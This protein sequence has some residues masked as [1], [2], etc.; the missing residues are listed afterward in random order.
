MNAFKSSP[1]YAEATE[2]LRMFFLRGQDVDPVYLREKGILNKVYDAQSEVHVI[3]ILGY[4]LNKPFADFKQP[5]QELDQLLRSGNIC[6]YA[7]EA[8]KQLEKVVRQMNSFRFELIPLVVVVEREK[9]QRL[10][11][12]LLVKAYHPLNTF[13]YVDISG[14]IYNSLSHFLDKNMLPRGFLCYPKNGEVVFDKRCGLAVD[15]QQVGEENNSKMCR[16]LLDA[17]ARNNWLMVS[18]NLLTFA[19][20][21]AAAGLAA[22]TKM[23]S[24]TVTQLGRL[25]LANR[26]IRGVSAGVN[27][28]TVLDSIGFAVVNW[29][30]M[31]IYE[32]I[33]LACSVC[34]CFREV[35]SFANAE[36]LIRA[37]QVEGLC[38]FFRG[39]AVSAGG[40]ISH[41]GQSFVAKV[42]TVFENNDEYLE[43]GLEL[44][45]ALVRDKFHVSVSDDFVF[46]KLFGFEYQ[47]RNIISMSK[48]ELNKFLYMIQGIASSFK[49]AFALLRKMF[50]D[51]PIAKAVFKRA[52][53]S[54]GNR[55]DYG[56]A[57]N[58]L[59]EIFNLCRQ[60]TNDITILTDAE[61]KIGNGHRF[62]IGTAFNTFIK[63]GPIMGMSL[64]R[65]LLE[66]N[67]R[68][69]ECLNRFR[70]QW[71]SKE[72]DIFKYVTHE[73]A[74]G[75]AILDKIRFLLDVFKTSTEVSLHITDLLPAEQVVEVEAMVRIGSDLFRQAV[76]Q[77]Q[78]LNPKILHICKVAL[79]NH[80]EFI[81]SMWNNTCVRPA[82]EDKSFEKLAVLQVAFESRTDC[83]IQN[84]ISYVSSMH[85]PDFS[86]FV[87]HS[88]FALDSMDA[89]VRETNLSE[90]D[91][92]GVLFSDLAPL[93]SRFQ[94]LTTLAK[95]LSLGGYF[96]VDD[97]L[98][99]AE[100]GPL[101]AALKDL[102]SQGSLHFGTG[103][104][105]ALHL[106]KYPM[107][108]LGQK[109]LQKYNRFIAEKKFDREEV[110]P[111]YDGKRMVLLGN[112]QLTIVV[113]VVRGAG[114]YIDTFRFTHMD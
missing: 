41:Y 91:A 100:Q 65:A 102:A 60:I 18:A 97:E 87:T 49:D 73:S 2:R 101:V 112:E 79:G 25:A 103:E 113:G 80:R 53:E 84:V 75:A 47:I 111:A 55:A 36:R 12:T 26:V 7:D 98:L 15:C 39:C 106:S 10:F 96:P 33:S 64:L 59:I 69:T 77:D 83:T 109:E 24:V 63:A 54:G 5:A 13:R 95:E 110:Q 42:K 40:E 46:I 34:F 37:S 94:E 32:K 44:V 31:N 88:L 30:R 28:V 66:M 14:R 71:G 89:L 9:E 92:N 19:S 61:L 45:L 72:V 57:I 29:N 8:K 76:N 1:A 107:L 4:A 78:L 114:A 99:N 82:T 51:G 74:D 58:E 104:N 22:A 70:N 56:K 50:G 85:C 81:Q 93:R 105:A 35:I 6:M 16:D 23:E 43:N 20:I 3:N 27:A 86:R 62:T 21:G 17:E 90:V 52:E 67:H 68:E 108:R 11:E 38:N 48:S